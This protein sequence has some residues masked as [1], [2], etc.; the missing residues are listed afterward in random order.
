MFVW[1]LDLQPNDER[2][3]W[4]EQLKAPLDGDP[5]IQKDEDFDDSFNQINQA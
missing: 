5:R 1:A 3:T 2:Q 4:A